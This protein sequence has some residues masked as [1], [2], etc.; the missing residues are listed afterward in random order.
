MGGYPHRLRQLQSLDGERAVSF[1]TPPAPEEIM[2]A[3]AEVQRLEHMVRTLRTP[4]TVVQ[5]LKEATTRLTQLRF[6]RAFFQDKAPHGTKLAAL[7]ARNKAF[8]E[9][10]KR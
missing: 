1:K 9:G 10:D 7:N 6:A 3:E 2:Q 8:W 4:I 5:K